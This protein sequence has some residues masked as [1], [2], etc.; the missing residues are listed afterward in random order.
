M[1]PRF[2]PTTT[3]QLRAALARGLALAA[4]AAFAGCDSTRTVSADSA[5]PPGAFGTAAPSEARARAA[6]ASAARIVPA[7]AVAYAS[8]AADSGGSD[9]PAPTT[10]DAVSTGEPAHSP[11]AAG[12]DPSDSVPA[13]PAAA[14]ML[15]RTG[16]ASVEVDSVETAVARVRQIAERLGGYIANASVA[17]GRDTV[18]SAMLEV[19]VP[20]A[21]FDA[22]VAGLRPL[23][24]VE[25]VSVEAQDVGEEFVDVSAQL[26]NGRRLESRLLA[27]ADRQSNR[28][29]DLVS[30][31]RELAR[32]RGEID[33]AEGRLR[34]LR[35]HAATST[36]TVTVHA[37]APIVGAS[38]P[39][40]PI[41]GAFRDAWHN[42]VALVAGLI[43][44]SGVLVPLGAVAGLGALAWRRWGRRGPAAVAPARGNA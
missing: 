20:A 8:A 18:H 1:R 15:I 26:A 2:R 28:L 19:K 16:R 11:A 9:A 24:R 5:V 22:L 39:G 23:G 40:S 29:A 31:E 3:A 33:R 25:T 6:I 30:V 41:A 7:R 12:G 37:R 4:A 10:L 43:A 27:L 21:R 35:A 13:A 38:S 44:A 34:Y 17:A 32:V 14:A 36:L 42:F